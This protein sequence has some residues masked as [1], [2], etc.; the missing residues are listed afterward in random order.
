MNRASEIVIR[1]LLDESHADQV[2][3]EGL[4]E[5]LYE[6]CEK[7][8]GDALLSRDR[9]INQALETPK[10]PD[11]QAFIVAA[12]RLHFEMATLNRDAANLENLLQM[13]DAI[14]NV[15]SNALGRR[16][17]VMKAVD[18]IRKLKTIP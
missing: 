9:L 5:A 10:H 17:S 6:G 7:G 14:T 18:S 13:C 12:V 1:W 15:P 3:S 11:L 16:I 4:V 8:E 2:F